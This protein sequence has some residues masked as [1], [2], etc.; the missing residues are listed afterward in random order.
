M[1]GGRAGGIPQPTARS[2][3]ACSLWPKRRVVQLP[4]AQAQQSEVP[5]E[6]ASVACVGVTTIIV[7]TRLRHVADR[8]V[9]A[10]HRSAQHAD[11][12]AGDQLWAASAGAADT[13]NVD[14][15]HPTRPASRL[16]L[17]CKAVCVRARRRFRTGWRCPPTAWSISPLYRNAILAWAGAPNCDSTY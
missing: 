13:L 9:A 2:G 10:R 17:W 15:S 3:A 12:P 5:T 16:M 6:P 14:T 7:T 4:M 1:T 8:G 11:R